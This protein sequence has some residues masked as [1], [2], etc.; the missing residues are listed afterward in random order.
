MRRTL[1]IL[2]PFIL[3]LFALGLGAIPLHR[4][5]V[6]ERDEVLA[7]LERETRSTE[8]LAG[9]MVA[10]A[11]SQTLRDAEA[12]FLAIEENALLDDTRVLWIDERGRQRLP[13]ERFT[14]R[15]ATPQAA[16]LWARLDGGQF[17]DVDETI[18]QRLQVLAQLN[19]ALSTG[20]RPGVEG[21]FRG[22]LR[23]RAQ[24]RL[25]VVVEVVTQL[26]A[27]E[28]LAA[29]AKPDR[30]LALLVLRDGIKTS[31]TQ[32][33][34]GV[35][36]YLVANREH[37][38]LADVELLGSRATTLGRALGIPVDD[39]VAAL[40]RPHPATWNVPDDLPQASL[41]EGGT[42][43]VERRSDQGVVGVTVELPAI[44][45]GTTE[46]MRT[47]GLLRPDDTLGPAPAH[48]DLDSLRIPVV[49][50]WREAA[51][52][53]A[54]S[55]YHLKTGMLATSIM[56]ALAALVAGWLAHWRRL[57][58]VALKSDF[59]AAVSHELRT[60]LTSMR[61]IAE[62]LQLRLGDDER[63]RDYPARLISDVD[64]LSLMVENLLSYNRLEKGRVTLR[65]TR[66]GLRELVE[67]VAHD[68][69]A[70]S[71]VPVEFD[72]DQLTDVQ[73]EADPQMLQLVFQNLFR[74][75]CQYNDRTPVHIAVSSVEGQPLC[76][77]VSDNG[78]GISPSEH[79]AVFEDFVRGSS[80]R[81]NDR[82]SGIGLSLCRQVMQLHGGSIAVHASSASGTTF[83][84]RLPVRGVG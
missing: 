53:Q 76:L 35:M 7:S 4:V 32:K 67:G 16:A 23:H 42:R 13:R 63:V 28:Q 37:L 11:L 83:I 56:L 61:L 50:T 24:H 71:P 59:V 26:W 82:G 3:A 84:L 17:V 40:D 79:R 31:G 8:E 60:P 27:L 2:P 9:R 69:G 19:T 30:N 77:L 10:R 45:M 36:P 55:R 25:G 72:L 1:T 46:R 75:A 44:I 78:R 47:L 15:N 12:L 70:H 51:R 64:G 58:F 22:L 49:T 57:R 66:L 48:V 52:E 74:N 29:R 68:V 14:Q 20:H 80:S 34:E 21:A 33:V 39:F 62:T 54:Q 81:S 73:V 43:Y 18:E 41:L 65:R 5:F 38:H 6:T